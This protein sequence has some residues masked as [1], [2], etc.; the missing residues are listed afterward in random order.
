MIDKHCLRKTACLGLI[1]VAGLGVPLARAQ[2]ATLASLQSM[3]TNKVAGL[4]AETQKKKLLAV[5]EYGADL[6]TTLKAVQKA[7]DFD[8]YVLVEKEVA[9]FKSEKTVPASSSA[10]QLATNLAAYQKKLETFNMESGGKKI[11]LSKQ[12]LDALVVLRKELMLQ[13]KMKEA[14]EVN[15]TAKLLDADIKQMEAWT[16]QTGDVAAAP[17]N[18]ETK[19]DA[20]FGDEPEPAK[21]KTITSET[22]KVTATS[23]SAAKKKS[24]KGPP[25]AIEFNGHFYQYCAEKMK[26][27]TAKSKCLTRSGH[28]VSITSKE[29]NDFVAGLVKGKS[30]VWIGLHKP[31]DAWKWVNLEKADYLNWG[32]GE[33]NITKRS[34]Y[35]GV[36]ICGF[37]RGEERYIS[38]SYVNGLY[39]PGYTEAS[40]EWGDAYS[41][42]GVDGYVCEWDE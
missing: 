1:F 22:I 4:E 26:W 6:Q 29:E 27:D 21:P 7:G 25:E 34:P 8:G 23:T 10:P 2:T 13:N 36:G 24:K 42:T 14:G 19:L 28:L 18:P 11:E 17:A 20:L 30:A 31:V 39:R 40:G 38:S 15:E 9:R 3:Y 16:S 37:I 35:M 33:P 12:Y 5:Q 41:D 32:S